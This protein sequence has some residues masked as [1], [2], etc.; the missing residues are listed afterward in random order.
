MARSGSILRAIPSRPAVLRARQGARAAREHRV[1]RR[2]HGS[3]PLDDLSP[4]IEVSLLRLEF[5][6]PQPAVMAAGET[7]PEE[8]ARAGQVLETGSLDRAVHGSAR[9]L[10]GME[11]L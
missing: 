1:H 10:A 2:E 7:L 5:R 3:E 11:P 4:S 8:R 6:L 9:E